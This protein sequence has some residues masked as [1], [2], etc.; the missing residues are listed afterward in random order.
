MAWMRRQSRAVRKYR[1]KPAMRDGVPVKVEMNVD[2]NF[3]IF[4]RP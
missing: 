4:T 2:V 3:Q 1:F